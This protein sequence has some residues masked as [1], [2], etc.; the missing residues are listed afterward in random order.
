MICSMVRSDLRSCGKTTWIV[1][2][3]ASTR[4]RRD[5]APDGELLVS[6]PCPQTS[7]TSSSSRAHLLVLV[8][9]ACNESHRHPLGIRTQVSS[10]KMG[11]LFG[12]NACGV[13]DDND[14]DDDDFFCVCPTLSVMRGGQSENS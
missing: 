13:C 4:R 8:I 7:F 14:D 6:P 5:S 3:S 1:W 12:G 11:N 9:V 2:V 10:R